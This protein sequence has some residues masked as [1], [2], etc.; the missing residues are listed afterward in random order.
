VALG[1]VLGS[2]ASASRRL[3]FI[4]ADIIA[5]FLWAWPPIIIGGGSIDGRSGIN[6]RTVCLQMGMAMPID[7]VIKKAAILGDGAHIMAARGSRRG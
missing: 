3:I 6:G 1:I 7:M 5:L 2:V 4:G